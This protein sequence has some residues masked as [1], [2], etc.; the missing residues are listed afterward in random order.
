MQIYNS[1]TRKKETLIPVHEDR[2]AGI[3]EQLSQFFT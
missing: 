1:L 3:P 2:P